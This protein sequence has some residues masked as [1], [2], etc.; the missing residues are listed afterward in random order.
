MQGHRLTSRHEGVALADQGLSQGGGVLQ[1]LGLVALEL[2]AGCLLQSA[3]Q[4][5]NGVVVGAS[6]HGPLLSVS[7]HIRLWLVQ[8]GQERGVSLYMSPNEAHE[9]GIAYFHKATCLMAPMA[10]IW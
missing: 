1:H 2:L 3:G 8:G 10:V 5:C 6:L 9:V 7:R 4:P